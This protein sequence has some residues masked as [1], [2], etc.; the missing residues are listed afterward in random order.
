M[1][2]RVFKSSAQLA[3]GIPARRE[4]PKVFADCV[5]FSGFFC[6]E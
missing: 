6:A 5:N 3:A 2:A 1:H 4:V